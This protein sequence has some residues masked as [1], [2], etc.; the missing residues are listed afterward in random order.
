MDINI[1]GTITR[2]IPTDDP[3]VFETIELAGFHINTTSPLV[4][5]EDYQVFPEVPYNVFAGVDTYFYSFESEEQ[6]R[7]LVPNAFP[8]PVEEVVIHE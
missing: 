7:Q 8:E 4:G 3:E 2:T 6:A 1:L 5:A